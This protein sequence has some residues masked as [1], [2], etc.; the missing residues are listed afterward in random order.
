M[1]EEKCLNRKGNFIEDEKGL[2]AYVTENLPSSH[3]FHTMEGKGGQTQIL[4]WIFTSFWSQA[5]HGT[6][7]KLFMAIKRST[8]REPFCMRANGKEKSP[9]MH[10]WIANNN[11][12]CM[13]STEAT[14]DCVIEPFRVRV[15]LFNIKPKRVHFC[16]W[17]TW[18]E[19]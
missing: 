17:W 3:Y 12:M 2:H 1:W 8:L 7:K 9:N 4:E 19:T 11:R 15:F 5:L 16:V 14:M 18:K 10:N 13:S 6:W